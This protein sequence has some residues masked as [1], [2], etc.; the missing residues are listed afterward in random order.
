VSRNRGIQCVY[1]SNSSMPT[2]RKTSRR[3]LTPAERAYLVDRRDAGESFDKIFK[4]TGVHKT[5][6]QN[7]VKNAQQ[8]NTTKSL[9]RADPRKTNTRT[10]RQL[11]RE[12][13]KSAANRRV[14]LKELAINFQPQLSTQTIQCCLQEHNVRKWLAK[15]RPQLKP[16]HI[17]ARY[18]WALEYYNWGPEEWK[19]VLW[20]DEC[21]VEKKC[22]KGPV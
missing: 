20:S 6:I 16:E 12:A 9:P 5:T 10:E 15:G 8:R 17:K 19:K 2:Q 1:P 7:T 21:L 3:E 4:E 11:Y 22:G 18:Q 13:R 14:P